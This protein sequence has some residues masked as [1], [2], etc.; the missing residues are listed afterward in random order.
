MDDGEIKQVEEI[1][2]RIGSL[3]SELLKQKELLAQHA[4][5]ISTDLAENRRYAVS[6]EAGEKDVVE[7]G[8]N[9]LERYGF[10]VVDNVIPVEKI[11]TVREEVELAGPLIEGNLKAIRDYIGTNGGEEEKRSL[12]QLAQ[13]D[14]DKIESQLKQNNRDLDS[15]ARRLEKAGAPWIE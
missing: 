10:A 15:L 8:C 14:L 7:A 4:Q 11:S 2:N 3:E 13:K 1:R 6:A 9:S 12:L 5:A